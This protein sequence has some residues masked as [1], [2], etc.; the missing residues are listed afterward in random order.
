MNDDL[1]ILNDVTEESLPRPYLGLSQI[2]E[3]CHR[4][5]QYDHYWA[6]TSKI[7]AR[8]QRLFQ[9]GH[10]SEEI[11]INDLKKIGIHTSGEQD[12]IIAT[13]GHWKGHIDGIGTYGDGYSFLLEFKTHNDKSFKEL[14]KKKVK[15]AKPTHYDQMT[16][17]MSYLGFPKALYMAVNKNNSEYYLEWVDLDREHAKELKRKELEIITADTLLPRIGSGTPTWFECK[18]CNAKDV[19]FNRTPVNLNCRTCEH[20]DVLDEGAWSCSLK[21]EQLT[22]EDQI[23]GC[24]KYNKSEMFL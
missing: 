23:K 7:S 14:T 4:K 2:G 21:G 9:V 24:G 10:D 22:V 5:L 13:A 20:V 11:M 3:K 8:L 17:Y 16:A 6:Y 18:L 1:I 12:E 19:C 15:E